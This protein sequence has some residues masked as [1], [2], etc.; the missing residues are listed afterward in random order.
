MLNSDIFSC[1]TSCEFFV[2]VSHSFDGLHGFLVWIKNAFNGFPSLI[3]IA[4]P[5]N[6]DFLLLIDNPVLFEVINAIEWLLYHKE[7]ELAAKS[8]HL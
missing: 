2:F 6:K 1:K 3:L 4:F 7:Y 8:I 5:A